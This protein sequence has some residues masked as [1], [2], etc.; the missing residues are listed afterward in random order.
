MPY[1]SRDGEG[2]ITGLYASETEDAHEI[3]PGDDPEV[4]A[5]LGLNKEG[6][7]PG[8]GLAQS[9]P[10]FVRVLEDLIDVLIDKGLILFTEFPPAAQQKLTRR[11]LLRSKLAEWGSILGPGGGTPR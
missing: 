2:G 5:F 7:T 8:A 6:A 4:L 10:A 1:V 9:D 11:R 3:L